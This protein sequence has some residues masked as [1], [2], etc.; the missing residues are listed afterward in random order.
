MTNQITIKDGIPELGIFA[1]NDDAWVSSKD[2]SK[3]FKKDHKHVL[4]KIEEIQL[5]VAD[6]FWATN[7]KKSSSKNRGKSYK[8]FELT[9]KAFSL[10]AMGYTG[11]KAM[12]FKVKYIEAFESMLSHIQSRCISKGGYKIMTSEIAR[13][14]DNSPLTF[15]K[16]ANMINTA[17]LGMS[18]RDFRSLNEIQINTRDAVVTEKLVELDEA[19]RMNARL[20]KAGLLFETRQK[21]IEKAFKDI[22]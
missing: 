7:F 16:E 17:V 18:A 3:L 13:N 10:I 11:K 5:N 1:K 6:K 4:K 15:S 22:V 19:Q 2:I 8:A 9:R 14:I 12:A 20:V 21:L